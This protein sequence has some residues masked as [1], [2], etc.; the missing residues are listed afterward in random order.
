MVKLVGSV[1]LALLDPVS[2]AG[3][4]PNCTGSSTLAVTSSPG[5]QPSDE[6][7]TVTPE[8]TVAD[9]P[10]VE[11]NCGSPAPLDWV[12]LLS[13][14][15]NGVPAIPSVQ[16]ASPSPGWTCSPYDVETEM[17]APVSP[18]SYST[19]AVGRQFEG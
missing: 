8:P 3:K 5:A 10:E 19:P 7:F 2:S 18:M 6:T 14:C 4:T 16:V 9:A 1:T 17:P 12:M 15:H 11:L 13:S